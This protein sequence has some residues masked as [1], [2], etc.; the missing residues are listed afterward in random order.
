M[1]EDECPYRLHARKIVGFI[2]HTDKK[3]DV[4]SHLEMC[5]RAAEHL[6]KCI[7]D[8]KKSDN[9]WGAQ[10][11]TLT[12]KVNS[13]EE[14]AVWIFMMFI[15]I[16]SSERSHLKLIMT[17]LLNTATLRS[18]DQ[19]EIIPFQVRSETVVSALIS[20][21]KGSLGYECAVLRCAAM[22]T[23]E[24]IWSETDIPDDI[25]ST[26]TSTTKK[27]AVCMDRVDREIKR[28]VENELTGEH[29][30]LTKLLVSVSSHSYLIWTRR[31]DL[32]S[33]LREC[34]SLNDGM[35]PSSRF[36]P[37]SCVTPINPTSLPPLLLL[38]QEKPNSRKSQRRISRVRRS[39]PPTS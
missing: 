25:Y 28:Y 39:T 27:M 15:E 22:F 18:S 20:Q 16:P 21:Y 30:H 32:A 4:F 1:S 34:A 33:D 8:M 31:R 29:P 24:Q 19:D 11:V 3:D 35:I 23:S 26:R 17:M 5:E 38:K 12:Y 7:L 9:P 36:Y 10:L 37:S 14:A 6:H 13:F 2:A